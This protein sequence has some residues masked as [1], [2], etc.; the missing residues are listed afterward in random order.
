[1]HFRKKDSENTTS[2]S[3]EV[4]TQEGDLIPQQGLQTS[5][6]EDDSAQSLTCHVY[7]NKNSLLQTAQANISKV[8]G[9]KKTTVRVILDNGSN[10]SYITE[11]ASRCLGLKAIAQ[12]NLSIS[13]FGQSQ[14]TPRR[15]DVVQVLVKGKKGGL[16][17]CI[18][19]T[20]VPYICSQLQMVKDPIWFKENYSCF[21]NYRTG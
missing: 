10:R 20:V 4:Q 15:C 2:N 11:E 5:L 18:T 1:M 6:I 7:T 14:Y 21:K 16:P 8:D 12:E 3:S 17:V 19:A 13:V 9:T